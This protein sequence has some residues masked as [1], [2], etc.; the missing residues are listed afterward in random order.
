LHGRASFPLIAS[1][2]PKQ[3]VSQGMFENTPITVTRVSTEQIAIMVTLGLQGSSG[4]LV[5]HDPVMIGFLRV[6]SAVI[7]L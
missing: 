3:G 5:S 4:A 1:P 6:V 2:H 7:E